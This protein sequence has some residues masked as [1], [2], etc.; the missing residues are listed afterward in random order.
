MDL[1]GIKKVLI[2][3]FITVVIWLALYYTWL[4]NIE[5]NVFFAD[6]GEALLILSTFF[7]IDKFLLTK[8]DT[9]E[10]IFV[11]KNIAAAIFYVAIAI[12]V[13]FAFN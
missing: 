2:L 13:G 10:E 8:I 5:F 9:Y 6:I 7:L 1:L 11:K 12:I 4:I 3:V